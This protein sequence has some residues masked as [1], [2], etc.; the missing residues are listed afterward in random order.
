LMLLLS[1]VALLRR[2][3]NGPAQCSTSARTER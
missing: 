3:R 2:S 1:I